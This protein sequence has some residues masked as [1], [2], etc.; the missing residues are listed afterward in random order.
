MR[1]S[2]VEAEL[3]ALVKRLA[4]FDA[5]SV[6]SG[7]GG[8]CTDVANHAATLRIEALAHLAALRCRG[9]RECKSADLRN[10]LNEELANSALA[11]QEDPVEDAF[12]ANVGN[13][14]GNSRIFM[15]LWEGS[16]S[17]LQFCLLAVV[18]S[19]SAEWAKAS[20]GPITGMLRLSEKVAERAAVGRNTLS[21][22]LPRQPILIPS[23]SLERSRQ[24]V[25]FSYCDLNNLQIGPPSLLPFVFP[26]SHID[27]LQSE[28]IGN[29][30]LE[31]FPL[32]MGEQS[33]IV[34]LPSA[35]SLACRRFLLET[36]ANHDAIA[37]LTASITKQHLQALIGFGLPGW[38][39][40]EVDPSA[41]TAPL[42]HEVMGVAADALFVHIIFA[43]DDLDEHLSKGIH[44]LQDLSKIV[45][46]SV[47]ARGPARAK[48]LGLDRGLTVVVHGGI[49]RGF[50]ADLGPRQTGWQAAAFG[51]HDFMLLGWDHDF[52]AVRLW[53]LLTQRDALEERGV[54]I[55]LMMGVL[56]FC[57]YAESRNFYLVP[58]DF[59]ISSGSMLM[60]QPDFAAGLRKRLRAAIDWHVSLQPDRKAWVA[61]QRASSSVFFKEMQDKPIYISLEHAKKGA[62][63]GCVETAQRTWWIKYEGPQEDVH[64]R[65]VAVQ[66]WELVQNWIWRSTNALEEALP[67]LPIGPILVTLKMDGTLTPS[68]LLVAEYPDNLVIPNVTGSGNEVL[69]ACTSHYLVAFRRAN[70]FGD[71]L[72]VRALIR[73]A[74][75]LVG[76]TPQAADINRLESTIV[77][78][79]SARF[80]HAIPPRTLSD[81]LLNRLDLPTPQFVPPEDRAWSQLGLAPSVQA[82]AP[83]TRLKGKA[84]STVILAAVDAVWHRIRDKLRT[85]DRFSVIRRCL[86]NHAS[87]E[88]DRSQWSI[89]ASAL[90]ALHE[91]TSDVVHAA[92]RREAD[93]ARTAIATRVLVEMAICECPINARRCDA[94]DHD[95]LL[96]NIVTLVEI[97]SFGDALHY[98]LAPTGVEL[99]KNG[100]LIFDRDFLERV[101]QPYMRDTGERT[102]RTAAGR[103][104]AAFDAGERPSKPTGIDRFEEVFRI[105]YGLTLRR[106]GRFALQI[107][108]V[109]IDRSE[110][111]LLMRSSQLRSI[112]LDDAEEKLDAN[113][114]I[115][116]LTL[117][118][119]SQWDEHSPKNATRK[120]W[121]P[122]RRNRR[123]SLMARPIIQLTQDEDPVCVVSPNMV[124]ATA[125][126][127]S[128]AYE[129]LLPSSLFYTADMV[130]WLGY[131][132][133]RRGHEF[134]NEVADLLRSGGFQALANVEMSRLGAPSTFGDV[135]VVAWRT[136]NDTCW[137]VECKSL[138][139]DLTIGEI[140]ERVREYADMT[141]TKRGPLRRHLN[142][143]EFLQANPQALATLVNAKRMRLRSAIVTERLSPLQYDKSVSGHVDLVA[144]LATVS[145]ELRR[146]S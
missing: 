121:Y 6:L 123:L 101:Q 71:R 37:D 48:S 108:Q 3:S 43:Q 38:G 59:S 111:P 135:D 105:E 15:G 58:D 100:M 81:D 102:F 10:W 29:S 120:D 68:E 90:L 18:S 36:A 7:I 86:E 39:V 107:S 13:P 74:Y 72:M 61:V 5:R 12:V 54:R 146:R 98:D 50:K 62:L 116:K 115:E 42:L 118:I 117:P 88:K 52:S 145:E 136:G 140:G 113:L 80:F 16:D 138:T 84:A 110:F 130:A 25:T 78:S 82:H 63:L 133:D 119:R 28:T 26:L 124:E 70:N 76:Q 31:R 24:Y 23:K 85:R 41:Q 27:R 46:D 93:R 112:L 109:A 55:P 131:A 8:L 104:G 83:G 57:A 64:A 132:A 33:L 35:I 19:L 1:V 2:V 21:T 92:N 143:V 65:R 73:G 95:E 99:A 91:D 53:K 87:I 60:I 139:K 49:G 56:N 9:I 114:A 134:N 137:L 126:Y 142:R 20:L 79:D 128:Q 103:Y 125:R 34:V 51:L 94:L 14:S 75:L 127:L 141:P 17:Y 32:W 40:V 11:G 44:H 144:D 129:G 22:G 77:P 66:L 69:I 67:G 106:L 30:L 4:K 45:T 96:A 97:A 122:W 89:T 47:I